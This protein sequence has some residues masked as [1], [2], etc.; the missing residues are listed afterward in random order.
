MASQANDES[1]IE[2]DPEPQCEAE[3][4]PTLQRFDID[5]EHHDPPPPRPVLIFDVY[6]QHARFSRKAVRYVRSC[7]GLVCYPPSGGG[8]SRERC[9]KLGKGTIP[10]Q[11]G[12]VTESCCGVWKCPPKGA[13]SEA[14]IHY[15]FTRSPSVA[16]P[17][18][19]KGKENLPKFLTLKG[20]APEPLVES[21]CPGVLCL[22]P[23]QI[24]DCVSDWSNS[25]EIHLPKDCLRGKK[26]CC[27]VWKCTR[28]DGSDIVMYG[29]LRRKL[30]LKWV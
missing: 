27:P 9:T 13:G 2:P 16:I 12:G 17:F 6:I 3:E 19:Y 14:S 23:L 18:E 5:Y 15:G 22:P 20:A 10:A 11:L 7:S 26:E 25:I 28:K 30:F 4:P 24:A 29:E 8:W 21:K 1:D